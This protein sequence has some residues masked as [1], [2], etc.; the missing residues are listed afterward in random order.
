LFLGGLVVTLLIMAAGQSLE[1]GALPVW[2]GQSLL[3][4]SELELLLK[5]EEEEEE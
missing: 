2:E 5:E 4:L 3:G 1:A